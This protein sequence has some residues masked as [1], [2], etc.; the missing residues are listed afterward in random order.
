MREHDNLKHFLLKDLFT[1]KIGPKEIDLAAKW[2]AKKG[3]QEMI[4]S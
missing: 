4:K 2:L 3:T 1:E